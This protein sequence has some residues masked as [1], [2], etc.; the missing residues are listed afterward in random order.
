M[1]SIT[2]LFALILWGSSV[3]GVSYAI[4]FQD[5]F[6]QDSA[7][8]IAQISI[9]KASVAT[10]PEGV[11]RWR[12]AVNNQMLY[13]GDWIYV[14]PAAQAKIKMDSGQVVEL[15]EDTQIQVR[16]VM[17]ENRENSY[18]LSLL[19]GSLVA[20]LKSGCK[21]CAGMTIKSEEKSIN[22]TSGESVVLKKEV[23]KSVKKLEDKTTLPVYSGAKTASMGVVEQT[24]ATTIVKT[25]VPL[26][27]AEVPQPENPP[28][29]FKVKPL[30]DIKIS[31]I[32]LR[33]RSLVG[34]IETDGS[35]SITYTTDY[36][37]SELKD[38]KII[39][40]V[41]LPPLPDVTRKILPAIQVFNGTKSAYI[42]GMSG[43]AEVAVP[44]EKI[45]ALAKITSAGFIKDYQV[46][47]LP[48]ILVEGNQPAPEDF[49]GNEVILTIRFLG[50]VAAKYVQV[51]LD[52]DSKDTNYANPW[53]TPKKVVRQDENKMGFL[54]SISDYR[55]LRSFIRGSKQIGIY[56]A[57]SSQQGVFLMRDKQFVGEIL[58]ALTKDTWE[59]LRVAVTEFKSDF[60]Y[61][62][63]RDSYYQQVL[64]SDLQTNV[65]KFLDQGKTLYVAKKGK[66][67]PV[68]RQFIKSNQ[69]VAQFIDAQAKAVFFDKVDI[70][71]SL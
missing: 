61:R 28:E 38:S 46:R 44:I 59:Y 43:M 6:F 22:I 57:S 41:Q 58:G 45:M 21:K 48:G 11:I 3:L 70:I 5:S 62:G 68:S 19:K 63:R 66:I 31:K 13:D 47:L 20:D 71:H 54:V 35:N 34:K 15:G 12:D 69:E 2:K 26:R 55:K 24:F 56:P 51:Y 33:I 64:G 30:G 37:A 17:R 14:P 50:D 27:V 1:P 29:E 67:Y 49:K 52:L 7:V 4:W 42:Q 23:G 36:K 9:S 65:N 60:I 39:I 53:V 40:R 16:A 25:V 8:S 18:V 32:D 10:R